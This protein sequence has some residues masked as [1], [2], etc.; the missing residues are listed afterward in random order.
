ME[1]QTVVNS[2]LLETVRDDAVQDAASGEDETSNEKYYRSQKEVD[3]AFSK[4]LAHER[5]KWEREASLH[6]EVERLKAQADRTPKPPETPELLL[7]QENKPASRGRKEQ[8]TTAS[9]I[10]SEF[11][12]KIQA[13]LETIQQEYPAFSMETAMENP[14]FGMM[15]A[16]GEPLER[17]VDYFYPE[18]RQD[19]IRREAED[20]VLERIRRRNVRPVSMGH[21]NFGS[22]HRDIAQMSDEEILDIDRRVKRGEKITL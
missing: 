13:E 22:F 14:L 7:E 9:P 5:R 4:R 19:Q 17:V 1:E 3:E 20:A 16:T 8:E 11:I 18:H 15:L 10:R 12:E 2:E 21:A 6:S